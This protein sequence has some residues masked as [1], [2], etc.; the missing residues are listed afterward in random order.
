MSASPPV[1]KSVPSERVTATRKRLIPTITPTFFHRLPLLIS[2]VRACSSSCPSYSFWCLDAA[3]L[4]AGDV[5]DIKRETRKSLLEEMES[6]TH[7]KYFARLILRCTN[8][9]RS[10]QRRT[11]TAVRWLAETS[12]FTGSRWSLWIWARYSGTGH[13]RPPPHR[14]KFLRVWRRQ[15]RRYQLQRV[16]SWFE[17]CVARHTRRAHAMYVIKYTRGLSRDNTFLL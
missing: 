10:W 5:E 4:F 6:L 7:C 9:N 2:Q 16:R 13:H 17:H 11:A 15:G 8:L 14:T 12:G 1:L 3:K